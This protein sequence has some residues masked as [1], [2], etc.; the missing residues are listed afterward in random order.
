MRL[1]IAF[2]ACVVYVSCSK[3]DQTKAYG[4]V[5]KEYQSYSKQVYRGH[6]S[7]TYWKYYAILYSFLGQCSSIKVAIKFSE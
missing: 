5:E 7:G 4:Y 2:A 6:Y 1:L 3:H